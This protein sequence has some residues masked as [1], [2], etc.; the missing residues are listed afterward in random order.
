MGNINTIL[1][2]VSATLAQQTA[3]APVKQ[4]PAPANT[5]TPATQ[6]NASFTSPSDSVVASAGLIT[7]SSNFAQL[8]SLLEVA[9]GGTQQVGDILQ[10]LLSLTQ[11]VPQSDDLSGI[12]SEF[13]TLFAQINQTAGGTTFGG[14]SLIAGAYTGDTGASSG[15]GAGAQQLSLP[16]LTTQA[17]FGSD[18]PPGI[19]TPQDLQ[20]TI[21]QLTSALTTTDTASQNIAGVLGQA[22]F[23]AA[24][25]NTALANNDAASSTLTDSDIEEGSATDGFSAL[26]G[27][28]A[29]TAQIQTGNLPANL[30]S[31]LQE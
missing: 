24:S 14:Q 23:A 8:G 7:A 6:T 25:V 27:S 2:S 10:Q 12:E 30:L 13:S 11:Q 26:F 5:E 4:A 19:S 18:T 16:N 28:P 22:S 17:L 20:N 29:A 1:N 21:A 9:Q 15:S 31:L 3:P